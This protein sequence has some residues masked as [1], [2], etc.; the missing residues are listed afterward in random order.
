MLVLISNDDGIHAPGIKALSKAIGS[1]ADILVV[2]PL[3]ERSTTGHTL[4]LNQPLRLVETKENHY[5]CNGYPADCII[6]AL[7][8]LLK[9]RQ[10]P[11]LIIT[12]INRG[13]NLGLDIYYSGTVAAARE[14]AFHG[15]P[16]IAMSTTVEINPSLDNTPYFESAANFALHLIQS[17][18]WKSI[19]P[20]GLLNVNVPNLPQQAIKGVRTTPLG[21]RYYTSRIIERLDGRDLPYYWLT[22]ESDTLSHQK[23]TDC[24]LAKRDYITLTPLDLNRQTTSNFDSWLDMT[25]DWE[26]NRRFFGENRASEASISP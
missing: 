5:G 7:L 18:A 2:A 21:K 3:E 15:I 12:G 23:G 24:Y 26:Q 14:G 9:K 20:L 10:L 6:L 17:G 11:D 8:H 19:P 25:R 1:V 4:T 16:S 13:G 22:G